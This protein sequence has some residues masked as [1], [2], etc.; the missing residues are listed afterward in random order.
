LKK[1]LAENSR[2]RMKYTSIFPDTENLLRISAS[3][4][5]CHPI[6]YRKISESI[7][8]TKDY[9]ANFGWLSF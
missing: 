3:E 6:L 9:P 8:Q 5:V 2:W 4:Y 1:C 7:P